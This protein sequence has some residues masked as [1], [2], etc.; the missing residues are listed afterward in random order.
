[1]TWFQGNDDEQIAEKPRA[2]SNLGHSKSVSI[3]RQGT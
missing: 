3:T 1:M 2:S